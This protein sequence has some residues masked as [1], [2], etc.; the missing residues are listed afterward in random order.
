MK[1]RNNDFKLDAGIHGSL[2]NFI[3]FVDI[4]LKDGRNRYNFDSFVT[5]NSEQ[6]V[7]I[8]LQ[9]EG[10]NDKTTLTGHIGDIV[11]TPV[12]SVFGESIVYSL[13]I[14]LK[15]DPIDT[16]YSRKLKRTSIFSSRRRYR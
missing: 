16:S 12:Y 5:L 13:I 2:K 1:L 7:P 8:N 11:V 14:K 4:Y 15:K 6:D 10:S 9:I 3:S